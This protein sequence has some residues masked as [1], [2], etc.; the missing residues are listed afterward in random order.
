VPTPRRRSLRPA[1]LLGATSICLA[2]L[3]PASASADAQPTPERAARAEARLTRLE[4]RRAARAQEHA[5]RLAARAER[6]ARRRAAH[7][8]SDTTEA[9]G[10][11][12]GPA[13]AGTGTEGAESESPPARGVGRH[14]SVT[15]A[16]SS[17]RVSAGESVEITGTVT[18][19]P[20]LAAS[21][22]RVVVYEGQGGQQA[23][24]LAPA[25]TAAVAADGSYSFTS[26]ALEANTVFRVHVGRRG[27]LTVVKVAPHVTIA[28]EPAA[29]APAASTGAHSA[30]VAPITFAGS[31]APYQP[32]A[33]V[34]LQVAYRSSPAQWRTVAYG[35]V[36]GDGGYSVSHAFRRPGET[37]VRTVAFAG[38][39]RMPAA[40][41]AVSFQA[42]APQNPNLTINV[43]NA[44]PRA[45]ETVTISGVASGAANQS[46]TL[47]AH[48]AG[49]GAPTVLTTTA[50]ENGSYS[51]AQTPLA[52]TAYRVAAAGQRSTT[53][54]ERVTLTISNV[55]VPSTAIAGQELQ[56]GGSI[57]PSEPGRT[58]LLERE[59]P[60]GTG[61]VVV[62]Q[63][64]SN[65]ESTFSIACA[66]PHVGTFTMR[67]KVPA[68]GLHALSTS[69]PFTVI[70]TA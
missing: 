36:G 67:F 7:G 40:S 2:I 3:L 38:K 37:L 56:L 20:G 22:Q 33:L 61:F 9:P 21:S 10:G 6:L 5:E 48:A 69:P 16:P 41:E 68:D 47:Y 28:E 29:A 70:V 50:D 17:R 39:H 52:N 66:F 59:N 18:C 32:G 31:V 45:G 55:D 14:C 23:R 46:V 27:A 64:Q 15:I 1:C 19:A 34:E 57:A 51:F 53:V 30:R 42:V 8:K 65:G 54:F 25:A 62:A 4:E 26:A 63:Q 12:D 35:R 43:S 13:E 60:S 44:A 58:V 11:G 24:S 49:S